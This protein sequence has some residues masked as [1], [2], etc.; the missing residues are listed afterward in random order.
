MLC[1]RKRLWRCRDIRLP[2]PHLERAGG[3]HHTAR[4]ADRAARAE[5][6]RRVGQNA[7]SVAEVA[8]ASGIG[9]AS[10]MRAVRE[11][12]AP[13]VDHLPRTQGVRGLGL[14]ETTFLAATPLAPT[15]YVTGMVA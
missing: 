6:C 9:W 7:D 13:L 1:W 8:R 2:D 4:A 11:H 12:G 15:S 10:A 3:R 14:D 5:I